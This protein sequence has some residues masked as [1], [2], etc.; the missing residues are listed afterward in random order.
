MEEQRIVWLG[1]LDE[2]VH[3]PEDIDL[4]RL[5]HGVLL[6][7]GQKNHILAS[8]AE[9]LIQISRHI[10]N[11]IDTPAQLTL[12]AEVVDTNHERLSLARA[13]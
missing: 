10:L 11:V 3:G 4:G 9:V 13:A 12:L 6:I 8:I 7:I 5:A 2:P 1:I